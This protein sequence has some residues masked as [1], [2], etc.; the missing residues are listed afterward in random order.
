MLWGL[1]EVEG[2]RR[3][4]MEYLIV[5]ISVSFFEAL[6]LFTLSCMPLSS[7]PFSFHF[8]SLTGIIGAVLTTI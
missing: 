1:G 7:F 8:T 4:R 2:R 5:I 6:L 3:A